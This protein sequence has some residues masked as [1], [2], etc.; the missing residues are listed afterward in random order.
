MI[1]RMTLLSC[2]LVAM[3]PACRC[4]RAS[5]ETAAGP[6]GTSSD[7]IIVRTAASVPSLPPSTGSSAPI[8]SASAPKPGR[9]PPD[10]VKVAGRYCV[11]RYESAMLDDQQRQASPYYPILE[12]GYD[13]WIEDRK[14]EADKLLG[15]DEDGG[16]D[17]GRRGPGADLPFPELPEWQRAAAANVKAASKAEMI[18]NAYL[19]MHSSRDGCQRAGKRLCTLEEWR[20]ACR[21][22][23]NTRFPWGDDYKSGRCNVFREEHPGHVIYNRFTVGMLDPRMNL[24]TSGGKPLL[25]KTG[26]SP[27]CKS[28]WGDDAVYDMIGN[29][30]EW[31][32]D[33]KGTFVGGFFSRNTKK[34]CDQVIDGHTAGYADYSTGGRCCRDLMEP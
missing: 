3:L 7:A 21:G 11:D 15:A 30:D 1:R 33:P 32:D 26:E 2:C 31:I 10:M 22:E 13:K 18:P 20:T 5:D 27:E 14:A 34:G 28:A 8:A 24:V 9:C 19:S 17:G 29:L 12:R 23:K 4:D 16:G 6:A 25:R